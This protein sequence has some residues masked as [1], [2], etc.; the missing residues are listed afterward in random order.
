MG[1]GGGGAGGGVTVTAE[2][3]V[4]QGGVILLHCLNDSKF[5]FKKTALG[6]NANDELRLKG[7]NITFAPL[8]HF[9]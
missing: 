1:G 4:K 6:K 8:I 7:G 3:E 2:M 5:S 9:I